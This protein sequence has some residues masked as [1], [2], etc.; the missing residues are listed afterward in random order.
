[1]TAV[2]KVLVVDDEAGLRET[3]AANLDL[4][5]YQV[6]EAG[7]AADA[8]A[9]CARER[10][11]VVLTDIRM[12]EVDGVALFRK[13]REAGHHMPV[14]LMTGFALEEL[15]DSAL[16]EGA[17]AVL[18]KPFEVRHALE[19]VDQASRGSVVLVIDDVAS[20]AETTAAALQESGLR[21]NVATSAE[22]AIPIVL[23]GQVDLCVIDLVMPRV[24]GAE[25]VTLLRQ[26]R[27]DVIVIAVSGQDVP[28][29]INHAAAQGMQTFLRKP[30]RMR[31]LVRAI[32][33]AR[34]SRRG[35]TAGAAAR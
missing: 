6:S 14:V 20:V 11:D 13:L 3:L 10:F 35:A 22:D 23:G 29:L 8:L 15:V 34:G 26:V 31:E 19:V 32:A 16:E 24:S 25:L 12:P 17:W 28:E 5:G 30:V 2:R 33:R 4:E 1:M 18:P 21:A 7:C 27:P 9:A